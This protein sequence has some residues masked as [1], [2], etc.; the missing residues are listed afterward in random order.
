LVS[1]Y[2]VRGARAEIPTTDALTYAGVLENIDGTPIAAASKNVAVQLWDAQSG[3]TKLCERDSLPTP[4][5]M[6]HFEVTMPGDCPPKLQAG[7][8]AYVDVLVDGASIGRTKIG[9][10]PYALEA[11]R[12]SEAAGGL[13][14][15]ITAAE[16]GLPGEWKPYSVGVV[17]RDQPAVPLDG[18]GAKTKGTY[19]RVG[20][21]IEV[22]IYTEFS[23]T[24]CS[25]VG[26]KCDKNAH[27]AW[28]LPTGPYIDLSKLPAES[29]YYND[30][31]TG[32]VAGPTTSSP[33]VVWAYYGNVVFVG[34][35]GT[36]NLLASDVLPGI[37]ALT[38]S[39]PVTP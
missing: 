5:T 23:E 8:P 2:A 26:S 3:G 22:R 12:A 21:S 1:G 36:G 34:V 32:L 37:V 6:G 11:G 10:V 7:K 17:E 16:K 35:V 33:G 13:D 27:V 20:D 28:T 38:F 30:H 14:A 29:P 4:L 39:V 18:I 9:A 19:R 15:R 24:P 31:G 25:K